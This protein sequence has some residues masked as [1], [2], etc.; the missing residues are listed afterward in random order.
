MVSKSHGFKRGTRKKFRIRE[1][2]MIKNFLQKFNIGDR[3]S[4]DIHPDVKRFP[5]HRFQGLTGK[6]VGLRGKSYI[7]DVFDRGKKK[8]VITKPVHIKKV[9]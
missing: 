1:K 4:I 5:H 9:S 7:I 2:P 8:T 6:V 3:V